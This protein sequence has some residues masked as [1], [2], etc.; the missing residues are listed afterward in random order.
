MIIKNF[1]PKKADKIFSSETGG[2]PSW[3]MELITHAHWRKMIYK[4]VEMHRDC[5]LLN[6]AIKTIS[7][8]GFQSE[9][10]TTTTAVNQMEVFIR[11]FDSTMGRIV[12]GVSG[13]LPDFTKLV[14]NGECTYLA[15]QMVLSSLVYDYPGGM[16]LVKVSARLKWKFK[17]AKVKA[18]VAVWLTDW[19]ID[20]LG[21]RLIGWSIDWLIDL[22]VCSMIDWLIVR[23]SYRFLSTFRSCR[24]STTASKTA[25]PCRRN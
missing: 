7:D 18:F 24:T 1:D 25:T 16:N 19:L 14:T 11:V 13:A 3:V 22:S 10:P 20:W 5:L 17:S 12:D 6:F 21:D 9:I 8:A 15:A 4:L 23:S 2:V